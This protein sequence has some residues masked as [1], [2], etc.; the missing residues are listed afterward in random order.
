M[1]KMKSHT[2]LGEKAITLIAL[3]V[4]IVILLILAGV[5]ITMT[6]GQNGLFAKAKYAKA[7]YEEAEVKEDFSMLMT[8][9]TW[10]NVA[11]KTNKSLPDYLKDNGATSVK[12]NSDGKT[13]DVEYKGYSF[14]ISKEES[15]ENPTTIVEGVKI[16]EGFVYVG[17]TKS[18]GIVISDNIDDKEAYK[19]ASVV[20]KNLKG[21]QFVWI[22]VENINEYKRTAY[23]IQVGTKEKD[24][25]TNSEKI[26]YS[27]S[28]TDYFIEALS[29]DEKESV[30]Q[31]KGYYIGRY[32]TGD[33]NS[34]E[35]KK[36]RT[37]DDGIA[38]EMTV[39]AGQVLYNY[40]KKDE[41]QTLAE[42]FSSDHGYKIKSKL[43]SSYAWDTAISFIQK[44]NS[45]YGSSSEEGNYL[46]TEFKYVDIDGVSKNK[47]A[48]D[49]DEY[50]LVP[51][52]QTTA[53]N[54]IYDMGGNAW[55][56]TTELYCDEKYSVH[57]GGSYS[58]D[59]ALCGAGDRNYNIDYA[60]IREG[61]RIV[62]F[63]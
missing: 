44:N 4:T 27:D 6:L 17:G 12:E 60:L 15:K 37:Y 53:V 39:K 7:A 59:Y 55:E 42:R 32:E 21:N 13:L 48:N 40:V 54:N 41:A 8:Q 25:S 43:I 2:S 57:R 28:V 26:N 31:N 45:D 50:K 49:V 10:D 3:V 52:G 22:P 51:T 34:T 19:D 47:A 63:M 20:G 33:K 62:L 30:T 16:P 23:S 18:S 46:N 36:L 14:N 1:K 58:N 61:F 29:N 9:Y 35:E 24:E 56:W 38:H 5:T 11:E